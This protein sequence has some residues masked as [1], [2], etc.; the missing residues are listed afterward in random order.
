MKMGNKEN[1]CDDG[2]ERKEKDYEKEQV[3]KI[4]AVL[5]WAEKKKKKKKKK[6]E[7]WGTEE[8]FA[9]VIILVRYTQVIFSLF[10][11]TFFGQFSSCHN[12]QALSL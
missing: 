1:Y 12:G 10:P 5:I 8:H 4:H 2:T 3:D 6:G 11:K 7:V 9:D